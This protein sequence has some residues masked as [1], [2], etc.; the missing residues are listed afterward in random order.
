MQQGL[1]PWGKAQRG[2]GHQGPQARSHVGGAGKPSAR[3]GLG[4]FKHWLWGCPW[5]STLLLLL[6]LLRLINLLPL[7][8]VERG[9]QA[10][11]LGP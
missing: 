8:V 4:C 10:Q 3:P 1:L 11:H 9:G 7:L 5:R 2:G 6:P